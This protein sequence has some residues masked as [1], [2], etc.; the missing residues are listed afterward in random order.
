[1]AIDIARLF[2]Q[3]LPL[4]LAKNEA[5]AKS[6]GAKYQ[7]NLAGAGEWNLDLS[8]TGPCC[9]TGVGPADCTLT[10]DAFDFQKLVDNPQGNGMLL[11]FAGKLKI[12]GTQS[13]VM[14]LQKLFT[15][16]A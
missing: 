5:A 11:F 7:V 8:A 1:M 6:I 10:M 15:L 14:K 4:I 16:K 3:E 9:R 13:Q 2:D 12:E